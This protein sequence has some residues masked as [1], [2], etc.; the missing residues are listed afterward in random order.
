M[1]WKPKRIKLIDTTLAFMQKAACR[2]VRNLILQGGC[3][4]ARGPLRFWEGHEN[5]FL[6]IKLLIQ[7]ENYWELTAVTCNFDSIKVGTGKIIP[8]TLIDYLVD[9]QRIRYYGEFLYS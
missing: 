1:G 7:A 3:E 8:G 6:P 2:Y 9:K 4:R 5:P